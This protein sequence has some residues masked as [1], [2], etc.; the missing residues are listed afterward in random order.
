M[1][2][3]VY[4]STRNLLAHC[5]PSPPLVSD[6]PPHPRLSPPLTHPLPHPRLLIEPTTRTPRPPST[7]LPRPPLTH[8]PGPPLTLP[9]SS[10]A[11]S[12][13]PFVENDVPIADV[14]EHVVRVADVV[15][16]E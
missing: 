8:L 15:E 4:V 3:Q 5:F 11:M 10:S 7:R 13:L 14:V 12:S 2:L 1:Y 6:S 16:S 9:P